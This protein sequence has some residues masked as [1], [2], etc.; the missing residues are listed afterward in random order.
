[1]TS[2]IAPPF[3]SFTGKRGDPAIAVQ[4][5]YAVADELPFPCRGLW[6]SADGTADFKD[7]RGE[8]IIGFPLFAGL[9]EVGAKQITAFTM[10]SLWALW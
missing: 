10:D 6:A 7:H 1:M 3:G 4:R 2:N 5:I 8:D 9:N